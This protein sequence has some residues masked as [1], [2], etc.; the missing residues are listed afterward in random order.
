MKGPLFPPL[1]T[2]VEAPVGADPFGEAVAMAHAGC[3][4]GAFHWSVEGAMARAALVLAPEVPLSRATVMTMALGSGLADALGALGPAE[5]AVQFRWPGEVLVNGAACGRLRA[6]AAPRGTTGIPDWLV[7][8]FD[9]FFARSG[10]GAPGDRPDLTSL[11]EEGCGDLAPGDLL[12]SV[13][14]HTLVRINAWEEEGPRA[15][16]ADWSG[17]LVGIGEAADAAG[18]RGVFLGLDEEGAMLMRCDGA[19]AQVAA[20]PLAIL[21]DAEGRA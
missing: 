5:T 13:A 11:S 18:R 20:I 4:A 6:D 3:E 19:E 12:E 7:V 15:L 16:H 1:L 21:F 14:R 9:L 10:I 2:G 17:R 8:G